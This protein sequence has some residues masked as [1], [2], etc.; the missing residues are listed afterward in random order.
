M[1]TYAFLKHINSLKGPT[2]LNQFGYTLSSPSPSIISGQAYLSDS[3]RFIQSGAGALSQTC[4]GVKFRCVGV[5]LPTGADHWLISY[6]GNATVRTS[7]IAG[8]RLNSDGSLEIRQREAGH[9]AQL[10]ITS[11]GVIAVNTTYT[12]EFRYIGSASS[13]GGYTLAV[14]GVVLLN[15]SGVVTT[16]SATI[17]SWLLGPAD[18]GTPYTIDDYFWDFVISSRSSTVISAHMLGVTTFYQQRPT[19]N[20]NSADF[21]PNTGTNWDAVNDSVIDLDATFVF[22]NNSGTGRDSYVMSD[23]PGGAPPIAAVAIWP[24]IKS[25]NN[26]S[27]SCASA[28]YSGGSYS[29]YDNYGINALTTPS[30][31][32]YGGDAQPF[33]PGVVAWTSSLLNAAEWGVV[34]TL[35]S[36]TPITGPHMSQFYV[37]VC[38]AGVPTSVAQPGYALIVG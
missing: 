7:P 8:L 23:L 12:I 38:C 2:T 32:Y 4:V 30:Y 18:T 15:A 28:L 25:L 9:T 17:A 11:P 20:G 26:G 1:T 35:T 27:W 19:A 29:N 21:T 24:C 36:G 22:L 33:A 16:Y 34:A 3:D 10:A 5:S 14:D 13:A 31:R 37:D 6:Y